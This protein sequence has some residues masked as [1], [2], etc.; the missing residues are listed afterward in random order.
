MTSFTDFRKGV[1]NGHEV[2]GISEL[3]KELEEFNTDNHPMRTTD[4]DSKDDLM[5]YIDQ[6]VIEISK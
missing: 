3:R 5:K 2:R 4:N 1:H 6:Q